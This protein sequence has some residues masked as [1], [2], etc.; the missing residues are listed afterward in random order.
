MQVMSSSYHAASGNIIVGLYDGQV[1]MWQTDP[2]IATPDS[3]TAP[4]VALPAHECVRERLAE[5]QAQAK[6]IEKLIEKAKD[7][8]RQYVSR[9]QERK[10]SISDLETKCAYISNDVLFPL[11][12]CV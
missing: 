5:A 6:D 7:G 3:Q 4:Q 1:E 8:L 10:N 2:Y 12:T 11:L 9:D